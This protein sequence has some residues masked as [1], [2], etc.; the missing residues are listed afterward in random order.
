MG[1]HT[2]THHNFKLFFSRLF[3]EMMVICKWILNVYFNLSCLKW[4]DQQC[5]RTI[6]WN[7]MQWIDAV[8]TKQ[9]EFNGMNLKW[10]ILQSI[11][12]IRCY[13]AHTLI[14]WNWQAVK[15]VIAKGMETNIMISFHSDYLHSVYVVAVTHKTFVDTLETQY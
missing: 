10:N 4:N 12:L 3:N 1:K 9:T 13:Y 8:V 5:L 11:N 14:I 6:H 2:V 15:A 7:D